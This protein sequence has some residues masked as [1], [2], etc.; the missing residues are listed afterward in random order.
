MGPAPAV[1]R[2]LGRNG[3]SNHPCANDDGI[4]VAFLLLISETRVGRLLS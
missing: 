4:L 3:I 1:A 2:K